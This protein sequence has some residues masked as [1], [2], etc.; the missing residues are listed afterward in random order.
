MGESFPIRVFGE[1][2]DGEGVRKKTEDQPIRKHDGAIKDRENDSGHETPENFGKSLPFFP[3][4]FEEVHLRLEEGVNE[5]GESGA[6]S[7]DKNK[8]N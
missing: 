2:F 5:G 3:D 6:L 7:Q 1:R 8:T 4:F